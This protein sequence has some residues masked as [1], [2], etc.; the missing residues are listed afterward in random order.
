MKEYI[1]DKRSP[2]PSSEKA[3]RVMSSIRAKNTKPETKLRKALWAIGLRYRMHDRKLP[4]S[5]DI[6]LKKYKLVIFVDGEFWHGKDWETRKSKIKSNPAFWIKKI[7]RNIQRDHEV[8]TQL[9]LLGYTTM[10]FWS[11]EVE[12][13]LG[14]CMRAIL[15]FVDDYDKVG[16]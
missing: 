11:L 3:S 16:E 6:I 1:R 8:N 9:N 7:E 12:K 13:N 15:N 4:G 5:P 2:V 14:Q 10:R